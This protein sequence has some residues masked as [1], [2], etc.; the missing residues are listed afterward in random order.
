M[1]LAFGLWLPLYPTRYFAGVVVAFFHIVLAVWDAKNGWALQP[2]WIAYGYLFSVVIFIGCIFALRKAL[3]TRAIGKR[4][5]GCAF[6]LWLIY[7]GSSLAIYVKASP[8]FA[9]PT[10]VLALSISLLL[11]PLAATAIAPLA[12]ASHRHG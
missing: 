5:F 6:C 4:L 7:I 2:L 12:L 11:V 1:L 3:I 9:I 10:P 8:S